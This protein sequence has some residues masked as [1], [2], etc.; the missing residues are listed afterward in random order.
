MT[1]NV[2]NLSSSGSQP[3]PEYSAVF[4]S[5]LPFGFRHGEL[6][7]R[8]LTK[9][10]AEA[11][12]TRGTEYFIWDDKLEGFGCRIYPSGKR[13]YLIQYKHRG[14]TRR[15]KI[16]K[17]GRL[18]TEEARKIA[19]G[20]LGEV[21][22]GGD[23]AEDRAATKKA[24]SVADLCRQYLDAAEKGLV[25]GKRN[26]PKKRSTLAV[27][28]GRIERHILPLL[29]SRLVKDLRPSDIAKFVRDVAAGKT[30][31]DIKTKKRGRA[32]VK[33]GQTAAMRAVGLLGG[34]LTYAVSEGIRSDNPA[35]SVEVKRFAHTRR[36]VA[37]KP[38]QFRA[39]GLPLDK[40]LLEGENPK[41]VV[42]V[43]L[44]TL[45]GCRRNE[46]AGLKRTEVDEDGSCL[47]LSDSKEGASLRPIGKA[48]FDVIR[49]VCP[50]DT[51]K[52]VLPSDRGSGHYLGL[53]KAWLRIRARATGLPDN[54]T[55]HGLRHS[56][57]SVANELG[58]TEATRAALLDHTASYSQTGDYT[59]S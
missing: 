56:F 37:L 51:S 19:R 30:K 33:G 46:I 22:Q 38:E 28:R 18:T 53:P 42:A 12:E 17:H 35:H 40:A 50:D 36:A 14:R 54:L 24:K 9:T 59:L 16:G 45:T 5:G 44:I 32:I 3:R 26:L 39:L 11:A 43:K 1:D 4:Y 55:L 52:Y 27:D 15:V 10:V 49:E 20:L 2:A 41:A 8:S 6:G 57:S 34:M 13:S 25:L 21:A 58:F 48:A 7:L 31:A 23:P 47:R 29:G